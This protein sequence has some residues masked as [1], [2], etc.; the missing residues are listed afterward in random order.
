[1]RPARVTVKPEIGTLDEHAIGAAANRR[2]VEH[3]EQH[4]PER[5]CRHQKEEPAC[6]HGEWT[7]RE[8]GDARD[9]GRDTAD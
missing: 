6:T 9:R 2:V 1:M 5:E 8:C 4:L 3:E 7:D